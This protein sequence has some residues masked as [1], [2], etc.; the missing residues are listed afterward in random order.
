MTLSKMKKRKRKTMKPSIKN[1]DIK[2]TSTELAPYVFS[3]K[4]IAENYDSLTDFLAKN[5][6][7]SSNMAMKISKVRTRLADLTSNDN[8]TPKTLKELDK[9]LFWCAENLKDQSELFNYCVSD[10]Q[11][12]QDDD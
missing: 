12:G 4:K 10:K 3:I 2:G 9:T 5:S 11:K 1:M 8:L 7:F 6:K